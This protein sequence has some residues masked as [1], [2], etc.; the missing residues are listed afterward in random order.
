MSE[1]YRAECIHDTLE[2]CILFKNVTLELG[3]YFIHT[4]ARSCPLLRAAWEIV[5]RA[6]LPVKVARNH[7]EHPLVLVGV[8]CARAGGHRRV[9]SK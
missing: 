3:V 1:I 2:A 9:P 4:S 8:V 5:A 7:A 6:R